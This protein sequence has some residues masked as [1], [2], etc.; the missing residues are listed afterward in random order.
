[1]NL[2]YR[3]FFDDVSDP[4][5]WFKFE[6]ID[7]GVRGILFFRNTKNNTEELDGKIKVYSRG[8]YV[9]E[10]IRGLIPKFVNL[11]SGIIECDN[12][13]LVV[14]RNT[15]REEN[16]QENILT[17]IS[18]C[19]AQEVTIYLNDMF[20]KHRDQYE[21][22][23]P[24]INAF[25]K[26]SILQDKTFASVM[27]RK[28]VFMDLTGKYYT[29]KEY[30]EKFGG[31]EGNEIYY[32]SD[33][34]DQA[35]Y[36]GIF[37]RCGLNALLFDHVIDQPFMQRYEVLNPSIKFIRIDS[38]I[39]ALFNGEMTEKDVKNSEIVENKF[40]NAIGSRIGNIRLKVSNL[41]HESI[42]AIIINDEK[43]RR[44]A[45]MMEIYGLIKATN[46]S[47]RKI[48]AKSTLLININNNI[49]RFILN[50]NNEETLNIIINQLFDLALLNQQALE[51]EDIEAFVNRSEALLIRTINC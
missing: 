5:F 31:P 33:A 26:Y 20:E 27:T 39:E 47:D 48:Q 32:S 51:P 4:L 50:S 22:H 18:E 25:V 24:N 15:I 42:S 11:Q 1:M 40:K 7:I 49:V 8:V 44:M 34:V 41:Q 17:L 3:E 13:P 38:N 21:A 6:S 16:S 29:I 36:I 12:L 43:A 46:F 19:L 23:W 30:I 45:D 2:F 28:A 37:K 14:S 35:Y 9:G 10:N